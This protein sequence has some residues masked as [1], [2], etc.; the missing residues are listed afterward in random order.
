MR[1]NKFLPALALSFIIAAICL[2]LLLPKS[3]DENKSD[4]HEF[5][6]NE[7]EAIDA[8]QFLSTAAAFPNKDIPQDA[9]MN[10]YM[11]Y[12][13]HF[14]QGISRA[15]T[16][17]WHS[18]GPNN[19]GGRTLGIALDP[20]DPEII[21]LGS[22]GGGLWKST[23]GGKGVNAWSFVPTGFPVSSV[24]SVAIAPDDNKIMYIG[25]GEVYT[26]GS[27]TNGLI[28]RPTRGSVGIGILKSTDGGASWKKSLDWSYQQQK[29][30]WKIIVNP[31][32]SSTVYAATT[33]G[34]YKS[35]NAGST[36]ALVLDQKM[37]TDMAIDKSDTS[38]VYAG[39]GNMSSVNKG[40]YQ[41]QN[42]G[43]SWTILSNGLPKN[44]QNGRIIVSVCEGNTNV[45]MAA[46]YNAYS[47]VGIYRSSNKGKSWRQVLPVSEIC[48]YQGWY[49]RGLLIKSDDTNSVVIGGVE[50]FRSKSGGNNFAQVSNLN[51]PSTL[52]SDIHDIIA[53]PNDPSKIY[54][55]TDGGLYRSDDFGTSYYE[56][57][58]AYVTSQHYIG[59]TSFVDTSTILS[60]LQDNYSI[61]YQ[62]N[63]YWIG[64]VGGDGCYNAINHK[65]E[66]VQYVAYQYL[67]VYRTTTGGSNYSSIINS[68]SDPAGTNRTAFLAP[69][70]LC[71]SN[72]DVMYAAG[73]SML[74][75]TDGGTNISNIGPG[76]L[77]GGN[78]ILSIAVSE[79]STDSIYCATAP[80]DARPMHVFRSIDGGKNYKDI[81]GTNLPNRY[82]RRITV[83][84]HN[85]KELYIVYSGFGN[86]H[87]FKSTDAG[88]SWTD[89]SVDLPNIPFH[90]LMVYPRNTKYL[91][92]GSDIGAFTSNDGGKTWKDF[93]EGW[94]D[95][96]MVFDLVYSP[97][98]QSI[99]AFTHGRGVYRRS[100]KPLFV[101]IPNNPTIGNGFTIYPNPA[102]ST[103][104]IQADNT[105]TQNTQIQCYDQKGAIIYTAKP[106]PGI[107]NVFSIDVSKWPAGTYLLSINN[108]NAICTK[109]LLVVH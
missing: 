85:S 50:L 16:D 37:V 81:T 10:A 46:V 109:R 79:S 92:A 13:T 2:N 99:L 45:V 1:S 21:W 94:G 70:L 4:R 104:F 62:G 30:I 97:I 61:G 63:K 75:S 12:K 66:S 3:N 22:A 7:R 54:V 64:L 34:V 84:P 26:Y 23:V 39:V 58:D 59:S 14:L 71:P 108:E 20:K 105:F 49:A 8:L 11:Y 18:I 86:G 53:N 43:K 55:L 60:G 47:T 19:V 77:D 28:D 31:Y 74:K 27:S 5:K 93:S 17:A 103:A 67:N 15:G 51:N 33:E 91:F 96:A 83:N 88:N 57:T 82:P 36:W 102:K 80:S 73:D 106:S 35:T 76:K 72:P 56:C 68:P 48:S 100:L 9:Y 95:M 44:S 89:I 41:T 24:T 42:A 98:D 29:G 32:K 69:Y 78:I 107:K 25:T 87:I 90:C 65:N 6:E 40:L 38:I 101:G 52:H